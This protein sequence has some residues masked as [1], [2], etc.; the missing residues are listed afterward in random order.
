MS[1]REGSLDITE[2]MALGEMEP[3]VREPVRRALQE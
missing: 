1:K 3:A 2:L